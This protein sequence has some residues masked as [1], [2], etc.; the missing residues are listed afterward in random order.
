MWFLSDN[1]RQRKAMSQE[2]I[3]EAGDEPPKGNGVVRFVVISDT[4]EQEDFVD[5]PS[6]DVLL[7]TGDFT[8]SG[9]E[10]AIKRFNEW[11]GKQDFTHKIVI[12]GNHELSLDSTFA[13]NTT[14]K[15]CDEVARMKSLLTNC[16]YLEDSSIVVEGYKIWGSPATPKCGN[17]AFSYER[18]KEAELQ[19]SFMEE[20]VDLVMTHGP[21]YDIGDRNSG[22]LKTGCPSLR[23][24]IMEVKPLVHLCGH[25]HEDRGIRVVDGITFINACSVDSLYRVSHKPWVFDLARKC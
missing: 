16:T 4:H 14:T 11:L 17:W 9:C 18:G 21:P 3:W 20:G 2:A 6:G 1:Y 12:A 24:R 15:G 22:G 19:W 8:M 5:L 13:T 23:K 25:I 10:G 7:H